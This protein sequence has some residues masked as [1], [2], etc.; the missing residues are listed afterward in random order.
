MNLEVI[1][2]TKD[3]EGGPAWTGKEPP[4]RARLLTRYHAT[5][6]TNE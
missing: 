3:H 2:G 5:E 4:H 1:Q 6:L